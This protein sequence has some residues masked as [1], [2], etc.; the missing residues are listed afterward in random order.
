MPLCQTI[1]GFECVVCL[2]I[3][4]CCV[5]VLR[6]FVYYFAIYKLFF[7]LLFLT[8]KPSVIQLH[9]TPT[10]ILSHM[11]LLSPI[12]F[13][14]FQF[15]NRLCSFKKKERKKNSCKCCVNRKV[16]VFTVFFFDIYFLVQFYHFL[17]FMSSAICPKSYFCGGIFQAISSLANVNNLFLI[18]FSFQILC[19]KV[20][21]YQF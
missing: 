5:K 17:L 1:I 11:N 18:F 15:F 8:T 4:S 6:R 14:R 19:K 12:V 2:K 9:F 20:V 3:C 13:A 21:L 7:F 16:L 10:H